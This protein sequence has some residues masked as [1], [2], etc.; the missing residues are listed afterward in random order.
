VRFV[1]SRHARQRLFERGIDPEAARL[2]A[3]TG[4]VVLRY[5]TDTPYPSRLVLGYDGGRPLHVLVA[6]P[7]NEDVKIIVT[8]YEPNS[9]QWLSGWKQRRPR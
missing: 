5:P 4:E 8:V 9:D 1:F 3:E 7:P 2:V 6:D